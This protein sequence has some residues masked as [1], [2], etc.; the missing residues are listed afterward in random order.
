ML[1]N[2]KRLNAKHFPMH[3]ISPQLLQFV[4]LS[5][6][7]S[8]SLSVRVYFNVCIFVN[9]VL[10]TIVESHMLEKNRKDI[11]RYDE[12]RKRRRTFIVIVVVMS[13]E[14][15]VCDIKTIIILS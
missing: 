12:G 9:S 10:M 13:R 8:L 1:V 3:N 6:S 11:M 7:L 15:N 14:M 5:L 4:S 2:E